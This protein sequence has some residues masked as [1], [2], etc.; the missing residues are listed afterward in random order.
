MI[1]ETTLLFLFFLSCYVFTDYNFTGY[2]DI[3]IFYI[4]KLLNKK[5]IS[6]ELTNN[7]DSKLKYNENN[8][9][10]YI[11]KYIDKYKN[12]K[13]IELT[14]DRL[15]EL[16]LVY[17]IENTPLGN[18]LMYYN[19]DDETFSYY[20]DHSI[21]YRYL[22]VCSRRYVITYNCKN[23][24]IDLEEELKN[25]ENE[26]NVEN[27]DNTDENDNSVKNSVISKSD[28]NNTNDEYNDKHNSNDVNN[29]DGSKKNVFVNFKNYNKNE[30]AIK[31]NIITDK[32]KNKNKN[33][34]QLDLSNYTIKTINNSKN[35]NIIIKDKSN[36]YNHLGK[37]INFDF[38]KKEE[39]KKIGNKNFSYKDFKTKLCY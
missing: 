17:I 26:K 38:L 15:K 25:K 37:F 39:Y 16:K 20:S 1:S 14:E 23:I 2:Y 5:N 13:N 31:K 33:Q 7:D 36:K 8:E 30:T 12:L 3:I 10:K 29:V 9:V 19:N 18:V 11:K 6:N 35:E 24:H 28:Y 22:E 27:K 4:N 21:P 34:N 32:D